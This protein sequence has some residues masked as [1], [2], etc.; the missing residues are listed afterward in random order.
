MPDP[1]IT[2]QDLSDYIGRDVTADPAALAAVDAACDV[3]R[4]ITEQTFDD[5]TLTVSLDGTGGDALVLPLRPAISATSVLVNGN[6]VTDFV[7]TPQGLLVRNTGTGGVSGS[8]PLGRQ[9]V[10]VTY[11]YGYG[12]D[13]IPR[14]VRM[15]ALQLAARLVIQGIVQSESIGDVSVS[16]GRNAIDLSENEL[17]ILGRYRASRS[18]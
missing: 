8:W 2:V 1:F 15:V 12:T 5:T 14:S 10:T 3:C 6:P 11:Q 7:L 17:R 16:Y 4:D 13:G 18:F 9:N